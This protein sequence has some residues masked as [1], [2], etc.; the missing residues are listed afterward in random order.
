MKS[1]ALVTGSSKRIGK[2]ICL[3]LAKKGYDIA[4]HYNSSIIEAENTSREIKELGVE[5]KTFRFDLSSVPKSIDLIN[6]VFDIFPNC[7]ILINNASFFEDKRL[8][9]IKIEDFDRDFNVNFKSAFFLTQQ[10]SKHKSASTIINIID[11]RVLKV[12]S[13]HIVYNLSKNAL[14]KFTQMSAKILAPKIRVNAICPGDI[15][16]LEGLDES[17]LIKRSK[18]LPLKKI[19]DVQNIITAIDYLIENE[20]VTGE[21]LYVDGGEHLL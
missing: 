15:L 3:F 16:P 4:L 18:R 10:F 5:C 8:M 13:S 1:A 9:D 21:C 17:Y 12:E 14:F 11:S 2:E 6:N 20:F 7:S 19:G